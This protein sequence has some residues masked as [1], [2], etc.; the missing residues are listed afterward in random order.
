M[1]ASGGVGPLK[2]MKKLHSVRGSIFQ[3]WQHLSDWSSGP[4]HFTI[5]SKNC[6]TVENH[7]IRET[8]HTSS[9]AKSVLQTVDPTGEKKKKRR[10]RKKQ[11]LELISWKDLSAVREIHKNKQEDWPTLSS[12]SR[13][14]TWRRWVLSFSWDGASLV[15]SQPR[16]SDLQNRALYILFWGYVHTSLSFRE[17]WGPCWSNRMSWVPPAR[18]TIGQPP[19]RQR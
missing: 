14:L 5:F 15:S 10:R 18:C 13:V 7:L 1:H 11:Q 3:S 12:V 9:G 6:W 16:L 2:K 19:S 17:E 8:T 4:K